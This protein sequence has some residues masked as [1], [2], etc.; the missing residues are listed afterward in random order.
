MGDTSGG[1]GAFVPSANM[2]KYARA[3]V[4]PDVPP[5]DS[6]R[7]EAAGVSLRGLK[8]WRSDPRFAEWLLAE[9]RRLFAENVWE[10]WTVLGRLAREGNVQAAR[11]FLDRFASDDGA[12]A[13]AAPETFR[14]LAALAEMQHAESIPPEDAGESC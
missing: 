13:S 12:D 14:A 5:E 3:C 2:L 6:A 1:E 8:R 10:I 9:T 7:C 4:A 11:L